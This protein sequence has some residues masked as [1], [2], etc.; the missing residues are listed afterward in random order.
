MLFLSTILHAQQSKNVLETSQ[1]EIDSSKVISLNK[2]CKAYLTKTLIVYKQ[3]KVIYSYGKTDRSYTV[4]SVRKSLVSLLYGIYEDKGLIN[5]RKSLGDLGIDDIQYLTVQEKSA[6]IIDLLKAKSGVYHP[7][8]FE[9]PKMWKKRPKRGSYKPGEFWFYNNWDYNA[10]TTIFEQETGISLFEAFKKDIAVPLQFDDF[11]IEDQRYVLE[12][13]RSIHA[14]TV[15]KLSGRDLLKLGIVMLHK[16]KKGKT[17]IVPEGWI[18][19]STTSYSDLGIL[20]GYGLCWWVAHK[21]E[22]YPFVKLPDGTFSARGTGEQNLVII[23]KFNMVIVHQ[24]E[25]NSPSDKMMK[26]TQFGKLL[27]TILKE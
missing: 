3:G 9:T 19:K 4:F 8:A 25:V 2:L 13:G 22:H 7:A 12:Q 14:A 26:V 16:G 17:S 23:P 1:I 10:L 18:K 21:G 6:K 11:K 24:T 27:Q 20:G 5:V 15:W